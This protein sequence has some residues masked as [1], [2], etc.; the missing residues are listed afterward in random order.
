MAFNADVERDQP[1]DIEFGYFPHYLAGTDR[2]HDVLSGVSYEGRD[3][4]KV[5]LP[6]GSGRLFLIG[7]PE[8][9]ERHLAWEKTTGNDR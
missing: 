1:I 7:G 2:F 6:S 4:R 8:A 9:W 3:L 5:V